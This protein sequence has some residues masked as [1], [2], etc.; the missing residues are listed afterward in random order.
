MTFGGEFFGLEIHVDGGAIY[1]IGDCTVSNCKHSGYLTKGDRND[2]FDQASSIHPGTVQ[3]S[4]L[5]A[6][7]GIEIPW[8]GCLKLLISNK[9]IDQIPLNSIVSLIIVFAGVCV[10]FV[11]LL[12]NKK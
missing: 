7:A 12:K 8:I 10:L 2:Y 5:K 1:A 4:D 6:I 3:K 11:L 9:N